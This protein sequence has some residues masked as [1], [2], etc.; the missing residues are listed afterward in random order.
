MRCIGK[1][2][3]LAFTAG[4]A[5][6][7]WTAVNCNEMILLYHSLIFPYAILMR[8]RPVSHRGT[9]VIILSNSASKKGMQ[10]PHPGIAKPVTAQQSISLG[11][12]LQ[13]GVVGNTDTAQIVCLGGGTL[14][15][16]KH[17]SL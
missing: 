1:T 9:C 14:A 17:Y 11:A 7:V 16:H 12:L 15:L 13:F 3:T 5:S 2:A 4:P 8:F 10:S 6:A